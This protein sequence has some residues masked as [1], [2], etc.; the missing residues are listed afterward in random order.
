M[1]RPDLVFFQKP[2]HYLVVRGYA[3][4]QVE[5]AIIV[6]E[7]P[8]DE[9]CRMGRMPAFLKQAV[10]VGLRPPP[11]N[12]FGGIVLGNILKVGLHG[13]NIGLLQMIAKQKT[14]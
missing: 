6:E 8:S 14:S 1:A 10:A 9:K 4:V 5:I 11:S 7:A 3:I 2:Q 13:L 12:G